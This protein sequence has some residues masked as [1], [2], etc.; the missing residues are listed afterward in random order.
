MIPSLREGIIMARPKSVFT[1]ELAARARAD[2]AALGRSDLATKLRAIASAAKYPA[3]QVADILGVA[4]ETIW[5][6]GAAYSKDGVAGL[7]A[8]PKKARGSKLTAAQKE[9]VLSWVDESRTPKGKHVHWTLEKLRQAAISEFGVALSVNA[10]WAWL[11][12]EGRKPKV[13][14][15][16]HYEADA[17]AQEDFKKN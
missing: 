7:Q 3:E 15:P 6:W 11:R 12:K 5:R 14:R 8:K 1:E 16:R 2:L 4:A 10:I 17:Q 9:E 13:P